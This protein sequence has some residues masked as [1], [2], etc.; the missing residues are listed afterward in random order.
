LLT[1]SLRGRRLGDHANL[2]L[3]FKKGIN[4][5]RFMTMD[6]LKHATFI[7]F[8]LVNFSSC[9]TVT[10]IETSLEHQKT[11]PKVSF[12][13]IGDSG[14]VSDNPKKNAIIKVANAAK[15]Y[16]A[17][18][19]CGFG[20]MAGDNIYPRGA[21]GQPDGVEDA[22][23]FKAVFL[24]PYGDF[25]QVSGDDFRLYAALG[26]HD[27]Y[28]SRAGALA[29]VEFL[30]ST[31]PFFMQD[32]F[33]SVKPPAGQGEVEVFVIDTEMLLAPRELERVKINDAGEPVDQNKKSAGGTPNA[34]PASIAEEQ[35]LV[36]LQAALASSAAKWKIVLAHHPL[37]ESKGSKFKQAE[38]LRKMLL[39]ILC[40]QAD[41]YFAGHQHTLEV[42]ED[43]CE[44]QSSEGSAKAKPLLHIVSGA[45]SK[46]RKINKRFKK[47]QSDNH[48]QLSN[49]WA[50]GKVAGFMY[51]TLQG[52]SIDVRALTVSKDGKKTREEYRQTFLR[53]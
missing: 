40:G 22:K 46:A 24:E 6:F 52:D 17:E 48:S 51:V 25:Q 3:L 35:Q 45:A 1:E 43:S 27:W 37:W 29:Q 2:M 26:N 7:L 30:K 10:A 36:W 33:Y 13:A 53:N 12:I 21:D 31:P 20:L 49:H 50:K 15:N 47:W 23:R 28:N 39:P 19:A 38:T 16:C 5:D 4:A 42:H 9:S 18:N 32:F 8:I 14:Y 34:L 11:K 44:A 41:A